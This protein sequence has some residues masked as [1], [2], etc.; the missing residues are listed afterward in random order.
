M[1]QRIQSVFL[2]IIAAS[3]VTMLFV[4][5]WV[6]GDVATEQ[7]V[8]LNAFKMV[9]EDRSSLIPIVLGSK[10]V[11]YIGVLAIAGAIVALFS[12]SQYKNRM[13]QMKLGL[14][15]SLIMAGLAICAM[16]VA[17]NAD[18]FMPENAAE[19]KL[20]ALLPIVAL[21]FNS[22]ANRF[23]RRD[24]KMVRDSERMR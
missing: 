22:L 5:I 6:K 21:L 15:N 8:V 17:G 24:E 16:L 9:H 18:T 4:P 3:L 14:L 23:I 7:Y 11:L 2:L 20:G 12:I 10:S 19:F 1:I 13:T